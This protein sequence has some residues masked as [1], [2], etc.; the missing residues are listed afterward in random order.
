MADPREFTQRRHG[1]QVDG[2][3]HE[4]YKASNVEFLP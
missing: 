2:Q 4:D 1:R 3:E